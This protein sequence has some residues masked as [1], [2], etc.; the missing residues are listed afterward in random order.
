MLKPNSYFKI[1]FLLLLGS[2][3]LFTACDNDDDGD[4]PAAFVLPSS[5]DAASFDANSATE[6][7]VRTQLSN[8]SSEMKKGRTGATVTKA[9]LDGIYTGT[10]EAVTTDYY[11][12]K[13]QGADKWL[14]E[15]AAASGGAYDPA[16]VTGEGGVAGAYLL[17][18]NGI[19]IEQLVEKGLFGAA[20][21]NHA[22]TLMKGDKTAATSDQIL[23][24]FGSHPDFPASNNGDKHM[25][26]DGFAATYAGRRT[27]GDDTNGLYFRIKNAL[28]KLQAATSAD[29][30]FTTEKE[31]AIAELQRA[32][33]ESQM[34]TVVNYC[35]ATITKLSASDYDNTDLTK[36]GS[37]MHSYSEGVGF[38]HG[39]RTIDPNYRVITDAQIDALLMKMKAPMN[40]TPTSYEFHRDPTP[41]TLAP[42]Q[43]VIDEIKMIY[44]FSD[45]QIEDFRLNFINEEDR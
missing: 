39:W 1:L 7:G 40:G 13:L 38:L 44:G 24:I 12:G 36:I 15:L 28:I 5:Y 26:P 8:L 20:L 31:E 18:E 21:Y 27:K 3:F 25:N 33:E 17:D 45:Q 23:K 34:A 43:E 41:A 16:A 35:Q 4:E 37:A 42:L 22:V 10:L 30:V 19:E 29:P 2:T 9:A 14:D 6:A 11:K 32:W